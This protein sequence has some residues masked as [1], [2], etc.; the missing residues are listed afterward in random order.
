MTKLFD[1]YSG[2]LEC[3]VSELR[4]FTPAKSGA[5]QTEQ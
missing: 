2:K 3:K 1:E 4:S 5:E